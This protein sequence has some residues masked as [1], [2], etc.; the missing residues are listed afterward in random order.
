MTDVTTAEAL[1]CASNQSSENCKSIVKITAQFNNL[2]FWIRCQILTPDSQKDREKRFE[3]FLKVAKALKKLNNF[4]SYL[5]VI[6]AL[7]SG[8]VKRLEWPK[9]IRKQIAEMVTIMDSRQ[10]F[11]NFRSELNKAKP[12]LIPY[13]G[14]ILQDLTFVNVGNPDYLPNNKDMLNFAKRWQQYAILDSV[15]RLTRWRYDIKP[16]HDILALFAD[17]NEQLDDEGWTRSYA[18]KRRD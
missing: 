5:A 12:P 3:K 9:H 16:D 4:N 8:P 11:S 15:D 7:D 18:I 14:L 1:L 10:S 13:F 2:S 6:S 17:F